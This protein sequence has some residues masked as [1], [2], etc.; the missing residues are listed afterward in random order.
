ME[1]KSGIPDKEGDPEEEEDED[2][3][4]RVEEGDGD[5]ED[6]PGGLPGDAATPRRPPPVPLARPQP[7]A[8]PW[9]DWAWEGTCRRAT[10]VGSQTATG[11]SQ[12]PATMCQASRRLR[13]NTRSGFSRFHHRS[14]PIA[15]VLPEA[16][17]RGGVGQM[18]Q[19]GACWVP[20]QGDG[21]G[22]K[23]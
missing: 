22:D 23:V 3:D 8:D 17:C 19:M 4:G 5:E 11:V 10:R 21:A 7:V 9:S 12:T 15:Q 20:V 6:R 18:E 16:R 13:R 14:K 1:V 2:G